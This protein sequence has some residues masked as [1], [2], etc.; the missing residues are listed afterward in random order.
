MTNNMM[1]TIFVVDI[2]YVRDDSIVL[3]VVLKKNKCLFI[4]LCE[5]WSEFLWNG[6]VVII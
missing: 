2:V 3:S 4:C 5:E 1:N 6:K